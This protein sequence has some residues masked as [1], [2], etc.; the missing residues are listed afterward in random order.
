MK[1]QSTA[2]RRAFPRV[3]TRVSVQLARPDAIVS[4]QMTATLLNVSQSGALVL[5][6]EWIAV[7]EW[8][9]L[10]PHTADPRHR[11]ELVAIVDK[12]TRLESGQVRLACRFPNRLDYSE[13]RHF[14]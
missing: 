10:Q 7:G 3:P 11:R 8:I 12:C 2:E 6:A 9:V 4:P 5:S 14:L 1:R 13:I